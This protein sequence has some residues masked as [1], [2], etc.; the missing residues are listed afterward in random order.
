MLKDWSSFQ[1]EDAGGRVWEAYE[2]RV[3]REL[4]RLELVKHKGMNV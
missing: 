4:E 3:M 1:K 2:S